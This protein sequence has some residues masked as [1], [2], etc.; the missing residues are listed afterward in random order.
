MLWEIWGRHRWSFLCQGIALAASVLFVHWRE[1]GASPAL[2]DLLGIATFACLIGA[3]SYL[4]VCFGYVEMDAGKIQFGFPGRLLFKPVSTGRLTLVPMLFGG[5]TMVSVFAVWAELVLR[6]LVN[7]SA[8]DLLWVSA[9]L[10]SFFWWMQA[11]A[12]CLPSFRGSVFVVIIVAVIHFVV[13]CIPRLPRSISPGWQWPIL[14][15]LLGFTVPATWIGLKLMRQGMWEGPSQIT[16]LWRHLRLPRARRRSEKF[17]SAFAAQFWLESRR[18]GWLLP[19]ISGGMVF[20]IFPLILKCFQWVGADTFPPE[21]LPGMLVLPLV[22]SVLLAPALARFDSF[23]ATN[24]LPVYI[25]VRPMTNGGFVLA[26]LVMALTTSV[27]TWLVTAG[28]ACFWLALIGKGDHFSRMGVLTP[29]GTISYT[30][31]CAPG[32][33]LLVIW[34]WK[35]LVAGVGVGLTG[36]PWIIAAS[37]YWRLVLIVG[38]VPLLGAV[39]NNVNFREAVLHWLPAIL[40]ACLT[41][42][43]AVSIAAFIWGWR[44]HAITADAIAWISGGWLACGLFVTGYTGLI[45]YMLQRTDLWIWVTLGGFLVLPLAD[46]AIAPLALAGSRHR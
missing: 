5:A 46:L 7:L 39:K 37:V 3:N 27:L 19:G 4:L 42:K 24:E 36:R 30:W 8:S 16:A 43:L 29:Y 45:C 11:L 33:L 23:H 21:V 32:L 41:A 20:L 17:G 28:S 22:L 14:T 13:W 40:I 12:W 44:R 2:Q 18:Q 25:A 38:L 26:K 35:N 31:G 1:N 34:T 6:H 9:V 10:L 15:V